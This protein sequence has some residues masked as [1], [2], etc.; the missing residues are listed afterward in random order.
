MAKW[1]PPADRGARPE[2][3]GVKMPGTA[4]NGTLR[5]IGH[6]Y[7]APTQLKIHLPW[8]R[9]EA[10]TGSITTRCF[11]LGLWREC[12]TDVYRTSRALRFQ[13]SG[14]RLH[15]RRIGRRVRR[16]G[17]GSDGSAGPRRRVWRSAFSSGRQEAFDQSPYRRGDHVSRRLALRTARRKPRWLSKSLP[18]DYA[19]EIAREKRRSPSFRRGSRRAYDRPDLP[20]WGRRRTSGACAQSGRNGRG[21][22]MRSATLPSF[23]PRERLYRTAATFLPRGRS[24]QSG[25]HRNCAQII[26]ASAGHQWGMPCTSPPARSAG[27][28]YLYSP[29]SQLEYRRTPPGAQFR[30]PSEITRRN[31]APF[32]GSSRS[33]RQYAGAFL[34]LAIYFEGFGLPIPEISGA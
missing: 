28:L 17:N 16:T 23:R 10:F 5:S 20:H 9:K 19:Y 13:F 12:T 6:P 32:F 27:R 24:A 1:P 14:G 26:F 33:H 2:N 30:T 34:S 18:F 8:S 29:P 11:R 25:G 4:R 15:P 31:G 3:G 21:S 22:P 7:R